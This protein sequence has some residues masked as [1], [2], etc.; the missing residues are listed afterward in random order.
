MNFAGRAAV[1]VAIAMTVVACSRNKETAQPVMDVGAAAKAIAEQLEKD[2]AALAT[3]QV[4]DVEI[5]SAAP[6]DSAAPGPGACRVE[7][8]IDGTIGF[9]LLL[10]HQ[11]N[12]K[13]LMGG[14]GGYM[15]NLTNFAQLPE[16][17][18]GR[19]ALE[20]G[21]ATA[22]TDSGHQGNFVDAAWA[23]GNPQA[24]EN[25]A[26]RAVHRTTEVSKQIIATYYPRKLERSYFFGCSRGGGH[27]L[28]MAQRYP[29]DFDGI[30]AGAPAFDWTGMMVEFLQN[31]QAVVPDPAGARSS[32]ITAENRKL[33]ADSLLKSC[34]A[35][36]GA[37]DGVIGDPRE[38]KFDP[39]TLPRCSETQST[40]CVTRRQ[41]AAIRAVYA[42]A[43]I[44]EERIYPGP[45]FGGEN[46]AG[47]WDVWMTSPAA[48]P[49]Q[50][51]TP[52]LHFAFGLQFARN[53]VFDDPD[54]TYVGYD[55]ADWRERTAELSKLLDAT[56]P[57]LRKFRDRGGKLIL[58]H[59]WSDSALPATRTV[60]YYEAAR[61][62][63]SGLNSYARLFMM[64]GVGHCGGGPGPDRADWIGALER[65]VEKRAAP[66]E[67]TASRIDPSGATQTVRPVCAW[68]QRAR[69]LSDGDP[70]SAS[71]WHCAD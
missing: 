51:G 49:L 59:G 34:D 19:P 3:L 2:C 36:D 25:F 22:S 44:G 20:R 62:V 5:K 13:F 28:M 71:G 23:L 7:G 64:P 43:L 38:C 68:P 24:R 31:Q 55:F 29:Q 10:P 33:L 70:N 12:G 42:D 9:E 14:G 54:W 66:D 58:W 69:L 46:D 53:F 57:D 41:L 26:H 35:L 52:N 16:M 15:G 60:E 4:A 39:A 45:P 8:L 56:D 47:G 63:E 50:P 6:R 18:M 1:M 48:G 32:V 21:Y 11:W 30:V 65:W 27:G 17:T 40:G 61:K 37:A 67:V